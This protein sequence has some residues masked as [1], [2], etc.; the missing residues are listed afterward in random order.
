MDAKHTTG[1][2]KRNYQANTIDGAEGQFVAGLNGVAGWDAR[3]MI[4]G[5]DLLAAL[6]DA[7]RHA[8]DEFMSS[9]ALSEPEWMHRA[10]NAIA[11]AGVEP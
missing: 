7:V 5:P 10:R 3:L 4:A 9:D 6:R 11:K 1:P 8:E 2:W